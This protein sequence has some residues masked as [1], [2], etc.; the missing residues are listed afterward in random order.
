MNQ[1]SRPLKE[2][3]LAGEQGSQN[4]TFAQKALAR[5]AGLDQ[6]EVGEVVDVRP[7]IV[8]SHDNTAAIRE[9]WLQFGQSR[10]VIPE[11]L[12]ITLDHAV[13]APTT[14]HAQNHAEIRR[15]VEE[16]G[17]RHFFEVGRGICHQVLSEEGWYCRGS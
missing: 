6:V 12:A 11:K 14:R 2:G 4:Q 16:Q 8:L 13:P 1:E 5:G 7:D 10:V 3:R 17:V 9:I 15:F